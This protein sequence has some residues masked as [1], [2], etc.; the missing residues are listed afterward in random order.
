MSAGICRTRRGRPLD[1][2]RAIRDKIAARVETLPAE[3]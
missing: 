1:E 3:L 2:V